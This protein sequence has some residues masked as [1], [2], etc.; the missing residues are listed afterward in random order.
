MEDRI[1][2]NTEE[3]SDIYDIDKQINESESTTSQPESNN[4][5]KA[6]RSV[7][8]ATNQDTDEI[9]KKLQIK[10]EEQEKLNQKNK[11]RYLR[12]LADY[13]NLEKR[14][15]TERSRLLKNA[16]F[17]LVIKL[18]DFSDTLEKAKSSFFDPEIKL[19]VLKDG[20]LAIEKQ[21]LT[22]L[23]NEG[24]EK[25][26]SLGSKFDPNFHEVV[27]VRTD[28]GEEDNIILEEVQP[29]YILNSSLLRPSKVIIAKK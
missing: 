21:F 13:E 15:K 28:S 16:T 17:N 20:F 12:A 11:D 26:D 27:S 19:D 5:S 4:E 3:N 25:L 29:G 10:L 22:I 14:T 23:K 18:L 1:P 7:E 9:I 8:Y 24:V 6:S 2:K